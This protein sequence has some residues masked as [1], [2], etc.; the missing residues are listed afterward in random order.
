MAE[1]EDL[2]VF[3]AVASTAKHEEIQHQA[4]KTV[5]TASHAAI[6]SA[7]RGSDHDPRTPAQHARTDF[8]HPQA[9]AIVMFQLQGGMILSLYPRTELAKDANI[10]FGPPKTGEFSIGQAVA[11]KEDVDALLAQAQAAGQP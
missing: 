1:H 9:G 10:A 6:L 2:G 3:G 5:E 7:L 4:D 8:R 11:S